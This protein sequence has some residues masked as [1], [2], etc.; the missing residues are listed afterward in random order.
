MG[1][2][3]EAGAGVELGLKGIGGC[4]KTTMLASP[5]C[6]VSEC[7]ALLRPLLDASGFDPTWLQSACGERSLTVNDELH[8]KPL[9]TPQPLVVVRWWH[10]VSV[11]RLMTCLW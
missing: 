3:C 4:A 9:S 2:S 6:G 11:L 8:V 7:S 10:A 1:D 5:F